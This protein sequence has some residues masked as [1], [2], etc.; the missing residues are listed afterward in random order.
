MKA[1]ATGDKTLKCVMAPATIIDVHQYRVNGGVSRTRSS[2]RSIVVVD[3]GKNVG[4]H[5]VDR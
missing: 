1:S 4:F 2:I 5:L 3:L